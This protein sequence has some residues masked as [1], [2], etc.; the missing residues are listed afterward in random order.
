[1]ILQKY[2]YPAVERNVVIQYR[3]GRWEWSGHSG[4]SL[5]EVIHTNCIVEAEV[6]E[7]RDI[8]LLR[9]RNLAPQLGMMPRL[10][11][12]A[13]NRVV[14]SEPNNNGDL[15]IQIRD[16]DKHDPMQYFGL[17]SENIE[18]RESKNERLFNSGN[19]W[20][21]ERDNLDNYGTIISTEISVTNTD[22]TRL[23]VKCTVRFQLPGSSEPREWSGYLNDKGREV[24]KTYLEEELP[25]G[26]FK[27]AEETNFPHRFE[28]DFNL[29]AITGE[30]KLIRRNDRA[31]C[32]F[33]YR[34]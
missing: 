20:T 17:P 33:T 23:N 6:V 32:I 19:S 22:M 11:F 25:W 27:I 16:I 24:I 14:G 8:I 28:M 34:L 13:N 30:T 29:P 12:E 15:E 3:D 21:Y 4:N 10:T 31:Q 1:M 5:R 7:E 18:I 9:T 26:R 2:F